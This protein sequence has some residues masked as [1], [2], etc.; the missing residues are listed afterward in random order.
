MWRGRRLDDDD[1][2]RAE[3]IQQLMCQGCID[4]P[5]IERRHEIDFHVYFAESLARLR[6]L[7]DDGLATVADRRITVTS[8]GRLLL[9][10]IAM[11]LDR[12]L[13]EPGAAAPRPCYSRV[14]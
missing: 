14:I 4:L 13:T 10:M 7:V 8:N 5:A 12:Y 1:V 2:L 11:C 9:R 6:P 3:I